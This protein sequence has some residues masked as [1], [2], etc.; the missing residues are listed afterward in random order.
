MLHVLVLGQRWR[1]RK[2]IELPSSVTGATSGVGHHI[3]R[4]LRKAVSGE[5]PVGLLK[6]VRQLSVAKARK[7]F[8]TMDSRHQNFISF[9][10]FFWRLTNGVAPFFW[11]CF[12]HITGNTAEFR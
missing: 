5:K 2:S 12:S 11:I 8:Y 4:K 7:Q 6:S 3:Q 10:K 9:S 1:L